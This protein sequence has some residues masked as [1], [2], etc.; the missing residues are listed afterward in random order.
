MD[1]AAQDLHD[2]TVEAFDRF[3]DT[4]AS[5]ADFELVDGDAGRPVRRSPQFHLILSRERFRRIRARP[6]EF[7]FQYL[8]ASQARGGY[9]FFRLACG[10]ER[11]C[12]F[13][14]A[15]TRFAEDRP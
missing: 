2:L 12:D 11:L 13:G 15:W 14:K 9:D 3:V 1:G 8:C 5:G 4:E 10:P 7:H 6:F